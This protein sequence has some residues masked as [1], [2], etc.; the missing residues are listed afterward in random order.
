MPFMPWQR[1]HYML[2]QQHVHTSMHWMFTLVT[3]FTLIPPSHFDTSIRLNKKLY[4]RGSIDIVTWHVC[5]RSAYVL[6][7]LQMLTVYWSG[8]CSYVPGK[9]LASASDEKSKKQHLLREPI[10]IIVV[11]LEYPMDAVHRPAT[12]SMSLDTLDVSISTPGLPLRHA[13][14]AGSR[15]MYR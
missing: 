5:K 11:E 2:H 7:L 10:F 8:C 1:H 3:K 6:L 4:I 12:S 13:S 15:A 9:P 14:H